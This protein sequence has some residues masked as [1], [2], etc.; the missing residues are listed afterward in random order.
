MAVEGITQTTQ[1]ISFK[2]DE[3]EFALDISRVKEVLDFIRP[4]RVPQTPEFMKGVINL[5]GAVVPVVDLKK[6]F[7]MDKTEETVNTRIIIGE[8]NIENKATVIGALADSVH[9]VFDL[10]PED[11][12]P[13]PSIGTNL[14]TAFIKGM[15]K[16]DET[17]TMILDI[18]RVFSFEEIELMA[19]ANRDNET[20]KKAE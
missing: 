10:D 13:A 6:K 4:T 19:S 12:E 2:L 9:E 14:N 16:R 15:G 20:D 8:V 17:F 1:Y 5:R 11:I 3:E 18:D 7:N